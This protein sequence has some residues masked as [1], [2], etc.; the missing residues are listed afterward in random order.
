LISS[1]AFGG[2]PNLTVTKIC[3]LDTT[4]AG[5]A[6]N[7]VNPGDTL[8]CTITINNTGDGIANGVTVTDV[9]DEDTTYVEGSITVDN[10]IIP[11]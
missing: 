10:A 7:E 8:I 4:A 6:D 5:G 11:D 9:L 1:S 2:S 3:E